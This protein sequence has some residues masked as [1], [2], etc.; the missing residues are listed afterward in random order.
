[1]KKI[2]GL[3]LLSI[4]MFISACEKDN[5]SETLSDVLIIK[6]KG[7]E[8]PA[9]IYGNGSEK[10]FLIILNGGPGGKG[11]EY[12]IG[13]IKDLEE[14][15]AVVY[16]D[17]RGSG[18]STGSYSGDDVTPELMAGDVLA[19]VKILK[20]KYGD[21]LKFFLLGHSWGGLLGSTVML[22]DQSPFK[23]WIEVDGGH[24]LK[25]LFDDLMVR[26]PEVAD[27]QIAK[28]HSVDFWT[29]V[30][31]KID[32]MKKEGYSDDASDEL[33]ELGYSAEEYLRA[34]SVL[35]D[36]KG[37]SI[38]LTNYLYEESTII[39]AISSI[40]I[41]T[42]LSYIWTTVDYTKDLSKIKIPSMIMWGK[43]DLVIPYNQGEEAFNNIGSAK[44]TWVLFESSGHSPMMDEH[45]KF[46]NEM[47]KF[48]EANKN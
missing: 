46:A 16:L 18:M 43:Y 41:N 42:T 39:T 31:S 19:L 13:G 21:D 48:I 34:D 2:T 7:A 25:E 26:F 47:I 29:D 35:G 14:K 27:E 6:R 11:L 40:T 9:Y 33:N 4:I 8:M 23:G 5:L 15:Y 1:M 30:K 3:L 12:R 17:Q 32:E 38:S 44:K 10:I 24:N 28:G 37:V 22:T 36:Q 20:H 45:E